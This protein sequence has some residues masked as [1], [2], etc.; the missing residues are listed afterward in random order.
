MS[1]DQYSTEDFIADESFQQWV[2]TPDASSDKFWKDF[3]HRYPHRQEAINDAREFL[4][5][6]KP[7]PQLAFDDIENIKQRFNDRIDH[8]EMHR[9]RS[10]VIQ[11]RI[12]YSI[13]ASIVIAIGFI[14]YLTTNQQ[15]GL[16]IFNASVQRQEASRGE[17]RYLELVDGTKVWLNSA[18]RLTYSNNFASEEKREVFLEGEAFFDVAENKDRPFIVN[19]ADIAIKVL[20]T[21]FNVKSYPGDAMV[22]TTLV[23]GKITL[24]SKQEGK[25]GGP[26]V[27]IPNEQAVFIKDS[28][29]IVLENNVPSDNFTDWKNGW[30]VFD[31][32]PF[33]YIKETLERWYNVTIVV[34]DENSLSCTFTARFKDKSLQEVLEIFK[35]TESSISYRI[36]GDHAYITGKLCE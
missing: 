36:D 3:L 10:L 21:A 1:Y 20:G 31:D 30:I 34:E 2:N 12:R 27:M 6:L 7:S 9:R 15:P 35:N 32:K 17:H 29:K 23:R 25:A 14:T 5:V 11:Q 33:S 28:K 24:E 18:S 16:S 8:D 13:A 19:T 26:V 4:L 22:E